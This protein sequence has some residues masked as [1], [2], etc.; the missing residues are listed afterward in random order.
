MIEDSEKLKSAVEGR[1]EHLADR[2]VPYLG[3]GL[4]WL[5]TRNVTRTLSVLMVGLF[6][7]IKACDA[8]GSS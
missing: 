8:T 4:T 5:L 3:T 6:L 1:A 2:L 7:R